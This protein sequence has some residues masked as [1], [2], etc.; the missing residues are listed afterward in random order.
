[1]PAKSKSVARSIIVL[2]L[3]TLAL[4][5]ALSANRISQQN[6]DETARASRPIQ[7]YTVGRGD[8]E[9]T[10]SAVGRTEAE[11][12]TRL[13]FLSA[14]RVIA[15]A[16]QVGDTVAPGD[17]LARQGDQDQQLALESAN[18][19]LQL[20]QIRRTALDDGPDES[21][22][23]IAQANIDAAR[24]A[25]V[26]AAGAVTDA[27]IQAAQLQYEGA[28]QALAD[29]QRARNT[30]GG[31]QSDEAYALLDARVGQVSFNVEVARLQLEQIQQGQPGMVGAAQ[32]RV[33]QAEAELARLQA[34]PST[35]E[36]ERADA[37][38]AQAQLG[39]DSAQQAL[40][41]LRLTAPFAGLI[42]A[43]N[44]EIGTLTVPGL[45]VIEIT[46]L[47]P[48]RLTVQVDEIDVRVITEGMAARVTF[49][50]L[51]DAELAA[52]LEQIAIVGQNAAGIVNYDVRVRLDDDDP[53]ARPGMTAEAVFVIE[54][55]RDALVVPNEYIRIDRLD[56]QAY[57]NRVMADGT[58]DEISV[59]L[60]LQG[61]NTSEIASGLREGEVIGIDLAGDSIGLFGS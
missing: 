48:L 51:P 38:I 55:R 46:D 28:Q 47:T 37:Q 4:P 5:I 1:M 10:V 61:Q 41:R 44:T 15:L 2:T 54:T 12:V 18:I 42:T 17:L 32:A 45:A 33:N 26:S 21:Q 49:D 43:V 36:I 57:I 34:P 9:L 35:A 60:G 29:A 39:V 25:V 22:L 16:V 8:V 14:G 11:Q 3:T 7:Q 27:D 40:D 24:G 52:T 20:A 31:G 53:R 6:A 19:A 59:T 56:G 23:R 58:L 13:S 30:A 50:A